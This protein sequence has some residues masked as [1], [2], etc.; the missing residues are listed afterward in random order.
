LRPAWQNRFYR[1]I[2]FAYL[3]SVDG[4]IFNSRT[5]QATVEALAGFGRPAVIAYPAADH[6][7]P[8]I[9]KDEMI[10]RARRPGPVSLLF[11]GNLIRRKGLHTVLAALS[12]LPEKAFTLEV[13]G[14]L[15]MDKGY[16]AAVRR[17]I[18]NLS[19]EPVVHLH[20]ALDGAALKEHYRHA[21]VFVLPSSYEGFGLVYLEGL[22]FGLPGIATTAGAAGEIISDGETGFLIPP[23][24]P[25]VL[26][27]RL[28]QLADDR[29]LLVRMSLAARQRYKLFPT[30]EKTAEK[31]R[32]FLRTL[33]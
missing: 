28:R 19:L 25:E 23:E 5:T 32:Y 21:Q 7:A 14:G 31:I 27:D 22:G 26:A 24:E 1:R 17:Q 6:L 33:A 13:V 12:R 18:A 4:F 9:D 20:G 10:Q 11:I 8:R 29:E 15:N 30:W 16:T 3:K 2:E